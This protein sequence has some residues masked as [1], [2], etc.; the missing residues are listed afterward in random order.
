MDGEIGGSSLLK[1]HLNKKASGKRLAF[2]MSGMETGDAPTTSH[3]NQ[4]FMSCVKEGLGGG[5]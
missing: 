5:V 3:R 1:R 2:L 4:S